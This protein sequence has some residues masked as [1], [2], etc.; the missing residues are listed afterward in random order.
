MQDSRINYV[1]VG[2]FVTAMIVAFITI[3]TIL[4]G[5]RGAVDNYFT[6]YNN[7]GGVKF[8]TLVF[9]EGYQIGQVSNIEP[10]RD[11]QNL[12]FKVDLEVEEG[13]KIPEDSLARA[14]VSGLLSAVAIDIRAG[15]SPTNLK[16]G[17]EIKGTSASNFFATLADIGAEFGDLSNN[18]LRPLLDNVN[19]YIRQLGDAT[20]QHMPEI[21]ANLEKISGNVE[22]ASG[23]IEKDILKP[24][25][26]NRI[27]AV[28]ANADK[29]AANLANVTQGLDET[30]KLLNDSIASV[31]KVVE[32]NKGNVDESMRN[33]RYT[34]DTVARYVDDIAHNADS[35]ARNMSEFSR[36]IRENPGLILGG[37]SRPDQAKERKDKET[38]K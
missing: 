15:K 20:V 34:L 1:V 7:V 21:M 33:L 37:A 22:R 17:S 4:A 5:S 36:S 27:D 31:N 25:N 9:Y 11:G 8:G 29:T 26:R 30:R 14:N 19:N 23:S 28:L 6:V 2:A 32:S 38:K 12:R 16:P 13:W 35:T 10:V 3:I 18:S 24:E